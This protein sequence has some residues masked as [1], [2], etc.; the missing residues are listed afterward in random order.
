M[1]AGLAMT[2]FVLATAALVRR[3]PVW[4]GRRLAAARFVDGSPPLVRPSRR[5]DL[6][7]AA[8]GAG[9]GVGGFAGDGGLFGGRVGG[10][11]GGGGA[12]ARR[13]DAVV[14]G[15]AVAGRWRAP[16]WFARAAARVGL[17]DAGTV[18]RLWPRWLAA[19]VA[20]VVLAVAVGGTLAAVLVVALSLAGPA[21][22]GPWWRERQQRRLEAQLPTFLD[23]VSSGL[24]AG[25]TLTVGVLDAA[26]RMPPPLRH[27]LAPMLAAVRSG[28][29]LD[30]ELDRW[31]ARGHSATVRM[32]VAA[33]V[34]G[35]GAGGPQADTIDAIADTLRA[36]LAV[37]AEARALASQARASAVVIVGA[38]VVFA[39][40][41]ALADPAVLQF[42]VGTPAGVACLAGGLALDAVGAAWM[43]TVTRG[44]S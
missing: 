28:S 30:D 5:V 41:A 4:H 21:A 7:P 24:R 42:L 23:A 38:P 18:E 15:S 20:A 3:W 11:E 37:A 29:G 9:G 39:V 36:R 6:D 14:V 12:P 33:L 32:V 2:V 22:A 1:I 31:A 17:V 19:M 10:S 44:G 8:R 43:R 16:S 13:G 34:I 26:D 27:Q 25:S 40:V 35:L